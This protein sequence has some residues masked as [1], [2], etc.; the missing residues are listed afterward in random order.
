MCKEP[1]G[2]GVRAR[3]K[4]R[5]LKGREPT[6]VEVRQFPVEEC[7]VTTADV[8]EAFNKGEEVRVTATSGVRFVLKRGL[9][10][11]LYTWS[12]KCRGY[13]GRFQKEIWRIASAEVKDE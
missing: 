4:L 6:E 9:I 11:R 2:C 13:D 1:W 12:L 8:L 5:Q 3:I 7:V 10:Q